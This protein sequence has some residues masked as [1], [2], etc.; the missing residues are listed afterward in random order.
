MKKEEEFL[1]SYIEGSF[2]PL[3]S[4]VREFDASKFFKILQG[5]PVILQGFSMPFWVFRGLFRVEV[6]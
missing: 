2:R 3:F 5:F 6:P 1:K 4:G